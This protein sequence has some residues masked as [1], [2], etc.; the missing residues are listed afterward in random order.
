MRIFFRLDPRMSPH[1]GIT[2]IHGFSA[3]VAVSR[4]V[5]W[6]KTHY[7]LLTVSINDR[8]FTKL[9]IFI[10]GEEMGKAVVEHPLF[11]V[12]DPLHYMCYTNRS[13]DDE[14]AGLS[15][16]FIEMAMY[17]KELSLKGRAEVLLHFEG[18]FLRKERNCRYFRK[19]QYGYSAPGTKDMELINGPVPWSISKLADGEYP[20]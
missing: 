19:G 14:A 20:S 3:T 12:N 13:K 4:L 18:I 10:D 11:V 6:N 5:E 1:F 2:D 16:G 8:L 15:V 7:F 9:N 17:N